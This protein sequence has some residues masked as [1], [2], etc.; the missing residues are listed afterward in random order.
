MNE[1]ASSLQE[2]VT[3]YL[4]QVIVTAVIAL[5]G[6]GIDTWFWRGSVDD[7]ISEGRDTIAAQE[8]RIGSLSDRSEKRYGMLADEIRDLERQLSTCSQGFSTHLAT[9]DFHIKTIDKLV[10]RVDRLEQKP[11]ARADPYT[12]SEGREQAARTDALE[13]RLKNLET[14]SN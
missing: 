9:A 13:R 11:T 12:G 7:H 6:F 5:M 4:G 8:S 10:E 2:G 1:F 3:K 14:K